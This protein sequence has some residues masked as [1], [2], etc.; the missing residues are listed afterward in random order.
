ML[1]R[2]ESDAAIP[3]LTD[4]LSDPEPAVRAAAISS[5]GLIFADSAVAGIIPLLDDP[6][7]KV[8]EE[9]LTALPR[10][11]VTASPELIQ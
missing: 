5:L 10:L 3:H 2:M 6:D 7:S 1:G 11:K 8:R 4:L 9:A